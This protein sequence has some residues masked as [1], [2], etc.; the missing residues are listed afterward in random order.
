M[1]YTLKWGGKKTKHMH[2]FCDKV[3]LLVESRF[4]YVFAFFFTRS[5]ILSRVHWNW[6]SIKSSFQKKVL[7]KYLYNL[8][9]FPYAWN[10]FCY[11]HL[12]KQTTLVRISTMKFPCLIHFY[13]TP[14]VFAAP[15][16]VAQPPSVAMSRDRSS[17]ALSSAAQMWCTA[18]PGRK[19]PADAAPARHA[20]PDVGPWD[21]G[22]Q[23]WNKVKRMS[24]TKVNLS[25]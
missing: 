19:H 14:F 8:H 4:L 1:V 18:H 2:I 3:Q 24:V 17:K 12:K 11:V 10:T 20:A 7:N 9:I 23:R 16:A 25:I 13:S 15:L 6:T 22:G 5:H 21:V